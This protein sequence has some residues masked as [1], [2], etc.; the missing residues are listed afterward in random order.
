MKRIIKYPVAFVLV[1]LFLIILVSL[2]DVCISREITS[3]NARDAYEYYMEKGVYSN[4]YDGYTDVLM[5]S[6]TTVPFER[7]VSNILIN[8]LSNNV[9]IVNGGG[10][11]TLLE[12]FEKQIGHGDRYEPYT[13]YFAYSTA[14]FRVLFSRY[15]L[16]E[17]RAILNTLVIIGICF[18]SYM[19]FRQ[20]N[21]IFDAIPFLV[22]IAVG[23]LLHFSGCLTF[24]VDIIMML[25]GCFG[26]LYLVNRE[27]IDWIMFFG[28]MGVMTFAVNYWSLPLLSLM[29]PLV[30]LYMVRAIKGTDVKTLCSNMIVCTVSWLVG[31][32]SEVIIR[33][34]SGR[35]LSDS[36]NSLEHLK[37]YMTSDSVFD[38]GSGRFQ[39]V[40]RLCTDF[41]SRRVVIMLAIS[42]SVLFILCLIEFYINR[43]AGR[44]IILMNLKIKAVSVLLAFIPIVW[45]LILYN[46][47]FH[48]FD[49]YML[50]T[51][52][53]AVYTAVSVGFI[54][55][56][57]SSVNKEQ[58]Q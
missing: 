30:L 31:F 9:S 44:E 28:I 22:M 23:D 50:C 53:F 19:I 27:N 26:V 57:G 12:G 47:T 38:S 5:I 45:L 54:K 46:H 29:G 42:I 1:N 41:F 15:T 24:A 21:R 8:V 43:G 36:S 35:I 10:E 58:L 48:G 11:E 56:I 16:R 34:L 13:N 20:R 3:D 55:E 7:P 52:I 49:R 25:I 2:I 51:S 18:V 37:M 32:G 40:S 33:I 14:G 6:N 39:N 4:N 17:I